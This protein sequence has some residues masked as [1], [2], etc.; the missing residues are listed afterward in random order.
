MYFDMRSWRQ[1]NNIGELLEWVPVLQSSEQPAD[2]SVA[3][4]SKHAA[5]V[6]GTM[7]AFWFLAEWLRQAYQMG[8]HRTDRYGNPL[9]FEL[10][11]RVDFEKTLK[12][13]IYKSLWNDKCELCS[14]AAY[15]C[16]KVQK[17]VFP[18]SRGDRQVRFML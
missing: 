17:V 4:V 15:R 11:G 2:C 18:A 12:V 13:P 1:Q 5:S 14:L 8:C 9:N 16:R 10:V 7:Q 6:S 3:G